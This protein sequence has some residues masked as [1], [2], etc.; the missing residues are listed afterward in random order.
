MCGAEKTRD[1]YYKASCCKD[2]LRGECKECVAKKQKVYNG[3]NSDAIS[4][5]KKKKYQEA[6]VNKRREKWSEYYAKNSEKIKL[7]AITYHYENREKVLQRKREYWHKNR[8]DL[9]EKKRQARIDNPQRYKELHKEWVKN[10][11]D[12]YKEMRRRYKHLRRSAQGRLSQGITDTLSKKQNGK[13]ACCNQ[14]LGSDFHIDHIIP[15]ALGGT[16]TDDNVQLMKP[17]C[18]RKKNAKH[19]IDYMQEKGYLL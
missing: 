12:R 5:H 17:S 1:Q 9:I 4:A 2:G 11:R 3:K 10:N 18:N 14:K 8:A 6:D 13:C 19:Q 15:L 16:N 7:R